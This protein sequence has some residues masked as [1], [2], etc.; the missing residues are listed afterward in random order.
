MVEGDVRHRGDAAVPRMCRVETPAQADLDERHVDAG[1]REMAEDDR[2]EQLELG[3]FAVAP[4]D[5][6]GDGQ[7]RL[8]VAREVGHRDRLTVDLDALAIGDKM[9]L[10]CL[11][12]PKAGGAE[13]APR[14]RE[15]TALAVGPADQ[16]PAQR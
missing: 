6:I 13:R 1:L 4:R 9:R 16:R 12:D 5:R 14:Q 2:R 8:G 10:G 11:A 7:D 15:D 3:G